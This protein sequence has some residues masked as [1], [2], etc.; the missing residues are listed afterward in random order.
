MAVGQSFATKD[1]DKHSQI[2]V[3]SYGYWTR[4]FNRDP[5]VLGKPIFVNGVPFALSALAR[6]A[7]TEWNPPAPPPTSGFRSRTAA[8]LTPG[9]C[10]PSATTSSTLAPTGDPD[11]HGASEDGVTTQQALARINP[12]FAHATYE[13][14]GQEEKKNLQK[15]ELK[16]VSAQ[17]LG[18]AS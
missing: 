11:A 14:L 15:L 10:P 1:E 12:L 9:E 7:S 4:R 5:G 8:S 17:G 18:T 2:A 6:R 13:T 16:L 3:I